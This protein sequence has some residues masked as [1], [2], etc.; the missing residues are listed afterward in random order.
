MRKHRR[1]FIKKDKLPSTLFFLN[2]Q[3]GSQKFLGRKGSR[4]SQREKESHK[5]KAD[6]NS[7]AFLH[8]S[9]NPCQ[10]LLLSHKLKIKDKESRNLPES[11]GCLCL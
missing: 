10:P 8:G 6:L 4:Q 1:N 9:C 2:P 5:D 11:E 3:S 7:L